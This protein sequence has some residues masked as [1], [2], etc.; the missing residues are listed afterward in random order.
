ME[1]DR[2]DAQEA[3][4]VTVTSISLV[5]FVL[6]VVYHLVT[7]TDTFLTALTS[8]KD[9]FMVLPHFRWATGHA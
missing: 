7:K 8:L 6:A 9:R 1:T 2:P 3:S 5:I 4:S